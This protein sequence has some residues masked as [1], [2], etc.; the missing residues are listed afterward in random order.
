MAQAWGDQVIAAG[1]DPVN[2]PAGV[3]QGTWIGFA[4]TYQDRPTT[5]QRPAHFD[6]DGRYKIR[7]KA[8]V[9]FVTGTTT[10]KI[11]PD[12]ESASYESRTGDTHL[13]RV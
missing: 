4:N 1:T 8:T 12:S 3:S 10:G 7:T 6:D 5:D 13:P 11:I 2:H 9:S